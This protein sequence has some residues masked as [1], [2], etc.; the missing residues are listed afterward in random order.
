MPNQISNTLEEI[1][2]Y[3]QKNP[4]LKKCHHFRFYSSNGIK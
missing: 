4:E 1:R 3:T 2:E